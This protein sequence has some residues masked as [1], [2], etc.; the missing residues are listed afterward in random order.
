MPSLALAVVLPQL[1]NNTLHAS[2]FKAASILLLLTA[3]SVAAAYAAGLIC[4]FFFRTAAPRLEESLGLRPFLLLQAAILC[5]GTLSVLVLLLLGTSLA[6][7]NWLLGPHRNA[8]FAELVCTLGVVACFLALLRL[9]NPEQYMPRPL[10]K[11]LGQRIYGSKGS[12]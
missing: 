3:V 11:L 7:Q 9:G 5:G 12:A 8:I 2:D 1:Q 10:P 4:R 6:R